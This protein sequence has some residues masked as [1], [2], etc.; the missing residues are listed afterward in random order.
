MKFAWPESQK[1]VSLKWGNI[2]SVPAAGSTGL[3]ISSIEAGASCLVGSGTS[4]SWADNGRA[5]KNAIA[6]QNRGRRDRKTQM[7]L[8]VCLFILQCPAIQRTQ[9]ETGCVGPV[10]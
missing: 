3:S 10:L 1:R 9:R 7:M 4:G 5:R 8:W 2:D 6:T